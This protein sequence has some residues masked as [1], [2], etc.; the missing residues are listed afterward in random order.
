MTGQYKSNP[1]NPMLSTH[2]DL[3]MLC[4][5]ETAE[6][7]GIYNMPHDAQVIENLRGLC[8]N[9]LN[10]AIDHFDLP[11]FITSGYRCPELNKLVGGIPE[12]QHQKGQAAD[13]M[14]GGIRNDQLA[15]WILENTPFDELILE[16]FDPSCG[17]YGWVHVSYVAEGAR[18]KVSTFD[19]ETYH[20][21]FHLLDLSR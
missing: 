20:D 10:P 3:Q 1:H 2:L 5:S 8:V 17:E 21:G 16:K 15:R 9:V 19:G 12:S 11:L 14:M 6:A 18:G 7:E 13:I 4:Y